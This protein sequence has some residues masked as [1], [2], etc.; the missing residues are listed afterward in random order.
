MKVAKIWIIQIYLENG[1]MAW[2]KPFLFTPTGFT[3]RM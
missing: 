2:V 1:A 3:P